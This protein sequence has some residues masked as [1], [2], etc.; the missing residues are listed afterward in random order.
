MSDSWDDE[1]SEDSMSA[2]SLVDFIEENEDIILLD[3]ND[4]AAVS[5]KYSQI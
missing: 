4:S 5:K 3:D 2:G 1:R